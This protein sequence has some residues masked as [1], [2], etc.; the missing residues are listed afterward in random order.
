MICLGI[1]RNHNASVCLV[2]DGKVLLHL[3]NERLTKIKYDCLPIHAMLEITKYV[4]YIDRLG[5][6][7]FAEQDI[8]YWE[9]KDIFTHLVDNLSRSFKG[10][11]FKTTDLSNHHHQLH[12]ACSFYNSGFENA[13][14]IVIDGM[15]SEIYFKLDGQRVY[16]REHTSVFQGSYPASFEL[17]EK[18]ISYPTEIKGKVDI[19]SRMHVSNHM[20]PAQAFGHSSEFF[21]FAHMDAGKLMGMAS[22]GQ[23]NECV[24]PI[25]VDGKLNNRLF[26]IDDNLT[27]MF[28]NN[29]NYPYMDL[30][31]DNFQAGADFAYALQTETQ[32]H[33]KEYILDW[34]QKTKTK[35]VCLSGGYF[36]NCVANYDIMKSLPDD[37]SLYIEPL[38]NDAG[39]SMGAAKMLYHGET[40]DMT[41]RKQENIYYGR[42]T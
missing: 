42:N 3:E 36:L 14:C 6:A 2:K 8:D 15:G 27:K 9:G 35:N 40:K 38:S 20:S 24:P 10:K 1:N 26:Y 16:G 11:P 32:K 29:K 21:G 17:L 33:V 13:L 18:H 39:T 5:I 30:A 23:L 25:Y 28:I 41:I 22:Y 37:V 34:V 4:D 12:A 7:A 31:R 19:D